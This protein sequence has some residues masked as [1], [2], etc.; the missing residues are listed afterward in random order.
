MKRNEIQIRD[1]FILTLPDTKEYY[2]YGT[3]DKNC[4]SDTATGFDCYVSTDLENWEGP[5]TAFSPSGDF[6]AD[7]HFWAPEVYAYNGAFYMFASFKAEGKCRGTQ[8]LRASSP[9]GPFV[10]TGKEP[11]TP[12]N[13]ECL[14]GTLYIDAD[15]KPWMV[16]CH[17]WTQVIDG[18]M[19]AVRLD[20]KLENTVGEPIVLFRASEAEWTVG[21]VHKMD[22]KDERVYVTDGPFLYKTADGQLLMIWSSGSEKGYA[23]GVARSV[24]GKIDGKWEHDDALLFDSNGGHGMIFKGFDGKLYI[25]LHSPNKTPN[26]RPCF[27][28]LE[29]INNSLKIK[30]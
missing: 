16:F 4:W 9:K 20:E 11:I 12:R 8:V 2:L 25:T 3:T 18:E 5:Y 1:P 17:E 19:M 23:V 29:E 22:G 7:R 27:I 21:S 28:E 6:W 30:G 14:D 13:M 15:N 26:E 10:P 24:S